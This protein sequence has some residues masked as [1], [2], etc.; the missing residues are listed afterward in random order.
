MRSSKVAPGVDRE[1]IAKVAQS[2]AKAVE[3]VMAR[4]SPLERGILMELFYNEN[5]RQAVCKKYQLS[6]EQ[7]KLAIFRAKT[8]LRKAWL[9]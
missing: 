3:H 5:D 6:R 4:L 1:T 9:P 2:R 7:L 8:K